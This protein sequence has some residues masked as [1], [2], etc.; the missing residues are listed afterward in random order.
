MKDRIK[1]FLV[2]FMIVILGMGSF[3]Y[4]QTVKE[5]TSRVKKNTP[6]QPLIVFPLPDV[7]VLKDME[8]QEDKSAILET[9]QL[10][11][12]LLDYRCNY[13]TSA[14]VKFFRTQMK[15]RGWQEVGVLS[16]KITLLVFK[17]DSNVVFITISEG[18]F[19][20]DVKIYGMIKR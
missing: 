1:I 7:P 19:S 3:V 18:T 6:A 14:L 5:Q 20:T 4:G 12:K 13:K 10:I 16:S 8:L 9:K 2:I 17:K 15:L 11:I